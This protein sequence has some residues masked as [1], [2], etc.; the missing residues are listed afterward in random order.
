MKGGI[1]ID[2]Q[3]LYTSSKS[4]EEYP[5]YLTKEE[6]EAI[7]IILNMAFIYSWELYNKKQGDKFYLQ[8]KEN[9]DIIEEYHNK[10]YQGILAVGENIKGKSKYVLDNIKLN[11]VLEPFLNKDDH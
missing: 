10:G 8:H 1:I 7:P 5:V 3:I 6:L 4:K 2:N 9:I 11:E